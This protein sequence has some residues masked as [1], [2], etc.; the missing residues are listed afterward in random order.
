MSFKTHS[1][2]NEGRSYKLIPTFFSAKNLFLPK[3]ENEKKNSVH[4]DCHTVRFPRD[5]KNERSKFYTATDDTIKFCFLN[6]KCV[7]M[8]RTG[9]IAKCR[10]CQQIHH[11]MTK[12]SKAAFGDEQPGLRKF[13]FFIVNFLKNDYQNVHVL[14]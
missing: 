14:K 12:V 7:P 11:K 5:S 3:I 9:N 1:S 6:K 8:Q 10:T 13:W 2:I 4:K